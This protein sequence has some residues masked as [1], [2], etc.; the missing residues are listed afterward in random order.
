MGITALHLFRVSVQ[1]A[2]WKLRFAVHF[3]QQG[4]TKAQLLIIAPCAHAHNG[5]KQL[6]CQL[7]SQ[8]VSLSVCLPV[9]PTKRSSDHL[10]GLG[11]FM[12]DM[13]NASSVTLASLYLEVSRFADTCIHF[14][15]HKYKKHFQKMH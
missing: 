9:S 11:D 14:L 5:V 2:K 6:L 8:S 3:Y 7:V 12:A 4:F 10:S 13:H 15:F 1:P